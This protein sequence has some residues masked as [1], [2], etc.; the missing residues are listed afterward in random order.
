VAEQ[1]AHV[2]KVAPLCTKVVVVKLKRMLVEKKVG[3]R[4]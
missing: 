2:A 4:E 3:K 1:L